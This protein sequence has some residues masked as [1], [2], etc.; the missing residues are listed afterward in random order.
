MS[1]CHCWSAAGDVRAG[2]GAQVYARE[3]LVDERLAER[4][5]EA[6]DHPLAFDAFLSIL[7]APKSAAGGLDDMLLRFRDQGGQVLLVYGREDPWWPPAPSPSHLGRLLTRNDLS[8]PP[9]ALPTHACML[10]VLGTS[11]RELISTQLITFAL[12]AR[13]VL[14][15]LRG[16]SRW[17][18]RHGP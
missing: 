10:V 11:L 7:F 2:C 17:L 13:A 15:L 12:A 6:A 16:A 14:T 3:D 18:S 8:C 5:L 1:R 9:H 4:I